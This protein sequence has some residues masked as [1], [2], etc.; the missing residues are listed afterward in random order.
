MSFPTAMIGNYKSI[1]GGKLKYSKI[2]RNQTTPAEKQ[3]HETRN[4]K[5][6]QNISWDKQEWKCKIEK[7]TGCTNHSNRGLHSDKSLHKEKHFI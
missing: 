1:T 4:Q 2:S 7:L 3:V 6:N 5:K